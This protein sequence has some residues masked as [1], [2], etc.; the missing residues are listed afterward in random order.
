MSV[1][2]V[3]QWFLTFF[4]ISYPFVKQDHQ[5][6]PQYTQWCS[7]IDN[8]NVT[9]KI[10]IG[11]TLWFSQFTLLEGGIYPRWTTGVDNILMNLVLK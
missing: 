7:S 10:Y 2:C 6:Y 9:K 11:C 3:D 4:Y 5:I 1:T 8:T